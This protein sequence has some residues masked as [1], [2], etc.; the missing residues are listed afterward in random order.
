MA[1]K[2]N[3]R[4]AS[5]QTFVRDQIEE[6]QKRFVAI[7]GEA[8]KALE[9]LRR[10]SPKDLRLLENPAVKQIS[11]RAEAA[12]SVMF[13]RLDA[14]Q[15]RLIA[16]SGV[17]SQAQIRELSREINRLSKKVDGLMDKKSK[18]EARA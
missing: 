7:E 11:R 5:V 6:A 17:A 16:A 14:L 10:F 18:P 13:K 3:G 15:N 1:S 2:Q 8:R 9:S 12:G 4:A